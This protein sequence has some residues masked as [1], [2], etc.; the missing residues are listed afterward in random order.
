MRKTSESAARYGEVVAAA[1]PRVTSRGF[2]VLEVMLAAFILAVAIATSITTLQRAFLSI[3]TARN[4]TLAGQI[5]QHELEKVRLKDWTTV[6]GY[7]DDDDLPIDTLFTSN[8]YIANLIANRGLRLAREV[9]VPE[10]D[11]VQLT[12]TVTWR[13]YDGRELSRSYVTYYARYGIYDFFYN[14]SS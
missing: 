11:I 12:Y 1:R 13:N 9:T 3:D 4:M 5:M 14:S 6:S 2:T 8:D 7:T 10:T